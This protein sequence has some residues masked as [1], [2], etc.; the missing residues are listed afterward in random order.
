MIQNA[1]KRLLS[2]KGNIL[3]GL[4]GGPDSM[5]LFELLKELKVN[6]HI[7]HIDHALQPSS[8]G[9]KKELERMAKKHS[10]AF[11]SITLSIDPSSKNLEEVLRNE[12]IKFFTS[13]INEYKLDM[14]VLGHQKDEKA[15]TMIK[16]FFEGGDLFNIPGIKEDAVYGKMKVVR[17]LLGTTKKEIVAFLEERGVSYYVD[18]TNFTEMNLRG[19]MRVSL[20]PTLEKS[21]GKNIVSP[22]CDLGE[23]VDD[24]A[25][26]LAREVSK[27]GEIEVKGAFGSFFPYIEKCDPYIYIQ[28]ILHRLKLRGIILSRDQKRVLKNAIHNKLIDIHLDLGKERLYFETVGLF[29]LNVEKY[30]PVKG[31]FKESLDW[32]TFWKGGTY[33][34][35]ETTKVDVKVVAEYHRRNKTP[36]CL[37]RIY[38]FPLTAILKKTTIGY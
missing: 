20:I 32:L 35:N 1:K 14:L 38:P 34:E 29:L 6:F 4:S 17:P 11:H 18:P 31:F 22:I 21:F 33:I 8:L 27:L 5:C 26:F 36:I 30:I 15:E 24:C 19:K 3:L 25:A 23:Q 9:V 16:R 2:L 13:L 37:R 10:I 7:A 12:R 28:Y